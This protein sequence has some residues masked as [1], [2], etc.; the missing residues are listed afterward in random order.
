MKKYLPLGSIVTLKEAEKKIMIIGR[1]QMSEDVL[2]DY[3]GVLFPEGYLNKDQLYVF[4]NSDIGSLYYMGMQ[5]EEE[6]T[7]RKKLAE[8]DQKNEEAEQ[9]K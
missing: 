8:L 6:F 5:N 2:Y 4:N 3:S 1:F 9:E 7:F